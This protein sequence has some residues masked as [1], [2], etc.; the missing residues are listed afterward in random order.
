[1]KVIADRLARIYRSFEHDAEAAIAELGA[2]CH[3]GI[4]F[5][6]PLQDLRGREAFL[7]M[8]RRIVGRARRVS[9]VVHDLA[10]GEDTLF[11][12]W[13][14]TYEPRRGPTI[15][16]VGATCFR[17]RDGLVVEQRD[18][19]DLLSSLAGSVPGLRYLYERFAARLG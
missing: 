11:L 19:W 2:L 3:P 16:F 12:S 15:A 4:E 8:N 13:T 10:V 14:M 17:V 18:Y 7:A 9:F 1:M 5:H 6:D